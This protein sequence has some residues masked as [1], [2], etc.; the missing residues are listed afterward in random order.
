MILTDPVSGDGLRTAMGRFTTGVTVVTAVVEDLDYAMTATAFTSVSLDPVLVLVSVE[1]EARLHDAVM[2]SGRWAVSVLDEHARPAATWF[3]LSGRP[4]YR[5][6]DRVAHRRGAHTGA[7]LLSDALAW[8]ECR[9]WA[10][11]DGGDHSLV[12]GEVLGLELPHPEQAPLVHFRGRYRRLAQL[13]G[14]AVEPGV[15]MT[16]E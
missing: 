14:M 4:L 9:S 7:A 11:Y 6:M 5:Q 13:S 12:V 16:V 3:A 8:L 15:P 2:A 1:K 10:V